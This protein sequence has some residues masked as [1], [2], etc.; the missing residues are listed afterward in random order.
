MKAVLVRSLTT[1]NSIKQFGAALAVLESALGSSAE[2][3]AETRAF[4]QNLGHAKCDKPVRE[5]GKINIPLGLAQVIT[6]MRPDGM[7]RKRMVTPSSTKEVEDMAA[8]TGSCELLSDGDANIAPSVTRPKPAPRTKR[9]QG[10]GEQQTAETKHTGGDEKETRRT[11]PRSKP[12]PMPRTLFTKRAEAQFDAETE[13]ERETGCAAP[14]QKPTP[15]PLTTF[16]QRFEA[17]SAAEIVDVPVASVDGVTEKFTQGEETVI[18][19]ENKPRV[20]SAFSCMMNALRKAHKG[21]FSRAPKL[22]KQLEIERASFSEAGAKLIASMSE[23]QQKVYVACLDSS[24]YKAMKKDKSLTQ[25]LQ[26]EISALLKS[27]QERSEEEA[28]QISDLLHAFKSFGRQRRLACGLAMLPLRVL[29]EG[30]D[31]DTKALIDYC[32]ALN[33]AADGS[34]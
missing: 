31:I 22:F 14:R 8:T 4:F 25:Q 26:V 27:V 19:S 3:F 32:D 21:L 20:L 10:T 15:L 16:P 1:P 17:P 28:A 34:H 29:Y 24:T 18:F 30:R 33:K 2:Q 9:T 12:T 6:S 23:D 13:A 11:A 5:V 7:G